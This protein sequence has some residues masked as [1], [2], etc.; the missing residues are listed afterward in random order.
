M[1]LLTL[2]AS[3]E[4]A[5]DLIGWDAANTDL[6]LAVELVVRDVSGQV[7]VEEGAEG[8]PIAPAAAEVC[9]LDVLQG[10]NKKGVGERVQNGTKL[11]QRLQIR[12]KRGG[13]KSLQ[14]FTQQYFS[15]PMM[16]LQLC[17]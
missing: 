11:V 12:V 14:N 15:P 6:V 9:D 16:R 13:G 1:L 17:N 8:Q 3:T 7:G 5:G 10:G 4:D 2:P